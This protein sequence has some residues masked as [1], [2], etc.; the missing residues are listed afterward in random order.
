[1]KR[2]LIVCGHLLICIVLLQGCWNSKDLQTMAYIT[3]IGMDYVDGQYVIYAQT[4]NFTNVARGDS[5][6]VGKNVPTWIGKGE[7]ETVTDAFN[8]IYATAQL[9]LFWGHVKALVVS[10]AFLKDHDRATEAYDMLNRYR[11]IRYNIL[12][13]GTNEPMREILSQKSNLNL[14]P[15]ETILDNPAQMNQQYSFLLSKSGYKFFANLQELSGSTFLPSI[16]LDQGSWSEDTKP[17][18]MFRLNG[19]YFFSDKKYRGWLS[20]KELKGYRWLEKSLDR[21]LVN[22]PDTDT[23]DASLVLSKPRPRISIET[24]N[25][26][27][28]YRIKIKINAYVDEMINDVSKRDLEEKTA[29]VIEEQI[30]YTYKKGLTMGVD[31]FNLT[32]ELYR[33]NPKK[34]RDDYVENEL[35]LNKDSIEEIEVNVNILHSG[36]YKMRVR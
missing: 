9:K 35:L 1:M 29:K 31:V 34:W 7:G 18:T 8:D 2:K 14:S 28:Y 13:Y 30:R 6:Q 22:V 12:V 4:L 16:I 21:T 20:E 25:G 19:G 17:R 23:P 5:A 36:K 15:L 33:S 24:R 27:V 10:E 3:A 32:R 11:E 26:K